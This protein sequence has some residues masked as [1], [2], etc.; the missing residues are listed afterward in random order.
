[1]RDA[2]KTKAQLVNELVILRDRVAALEEELGNNSRA[3]AER[4]KT[5]HALHE[6]MKELNCFYTI[7]RL[8]DQHTEFLGELLGAIVQSLP[9]SWQ[10]PE[11]TCARIVFGQQEYTTSN[12]QRTPWRQIA[13]LCVAGDVAGVV[14]VCY[15][16]EMPALDEGPFLKE[17]RLLIDAVTERIG[18]IIERMHAKEQL[19][20]E[21]SSL[22]Q[23]NIA[24]RQLMGRVQEERAE[25]GESVQSN[26]DKMIL[27]ILDALESGASEQQGRYLAL[28]RRNLEEIA[29]PFADRLAKSFVGLTPSQLSI[30]DMVRRGLTTKEIA[31]LRNISPATV[32]RHREHIRRKLALT[33]TD[34][35]LTTYLNA[36][37][38]DYAPRTE[39]AG[40]VRTGN[41][42]TEH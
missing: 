15:L 23:A 7:T 8:V 11:V 28:L 25:V 20:L 3:S 19:Q 27:P 30:C 40:S 18:K 24:M 9:V 38:S 31:R 36:F 1:M 14:E 32:N 21:R 16:A 12:F 26:V 33:H 34:A 6:R 35:N 22:Q 17:E 2:N 42:G 37:M 10:Y 13:E 29:S 4:L 5:E 41:K 39:A